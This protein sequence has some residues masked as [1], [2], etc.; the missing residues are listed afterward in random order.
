MVKELRYTL[1]RPENFKVNLAFIKAGE[2]KMEYVYIKQNLF[3][4]FFF[5]L[6]IA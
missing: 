2:F 6:I 4:Y 1:Y 3:G 5:S